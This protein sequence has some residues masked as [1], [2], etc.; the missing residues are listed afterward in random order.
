MPYAFRL[1]RRVSARIVFNSRAI[2]RSSNHRHHPWAR[3]EPMLH[4]KRKVKLDRRFC[5]LFSGHEREPCS[6]LRHSID[7]NSCFHYCTMHERLILTDYSCS[8]SQGLRDDSNKSRATD[9]ADLLTKE[10]ES[11]RVSDVHASMK[12]RR[13]SSVSRNESNNSRLLSDKEQQLPIAPEAAPPC[14]RNPLKHHTRV[15]LCSGSQWPSK[16]FW[17]LS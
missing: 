7:S 16:L 15:W 9:E 10:N 4:C 5:H 2:N 17:W 13:A 1:N 6:E 12:V 14:S 3:H 8:H 11:L